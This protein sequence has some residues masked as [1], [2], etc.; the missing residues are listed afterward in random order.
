MGEQTPKIP[1]FLYQSLHGEVNP[2]EDVDRLVKNYCDNGSY[3]QYYGDTASIHAALG[4]TGTLD[5]INWITKRF[6]GE[7]VPK[8][9]SAETAV[10]CLDR[11][12]AVETLGVVGDQAVQT[13]WQFW[14]SSWPQKFEGQVGI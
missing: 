10:T 11:P 7:E 1:Q 8:D 5:G 13:C 3:V 4:L 2:I 14:G 9:C 6:D 12:L